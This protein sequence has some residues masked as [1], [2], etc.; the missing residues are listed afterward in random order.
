MRKDIGVQFP[1]FVGEG[2]VHGEK[3][4]AVLGLQRTGN[5]VHLSPG[6]GNLPQAG[7]LRTHLAEKI[8]REAAVDGDEVVQ[9]PDGGGIVDVSHRRG[10]D[11]VV[12]VQKVIQLP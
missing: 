5:E 7:G 2:R 10:Q 11:C 6:A 1:G 3:G 4:P 9:F 8:H 12:V